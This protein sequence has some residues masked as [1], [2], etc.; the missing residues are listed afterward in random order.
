[1]KRL[2]ALLLALCL[3]GGAFTALA[4]ET[5]EATPLPGYT[6]RASADEV[7]VFAT[8]SMKANIVGYILP[9]GQQEVQVLRVQGEWCYIRFTS[10]YGDSYGYLPLACF[11]VAPQPTATPTPEIGFEVGTLAWVVNPAEGYRVNLREEPSPT[12]ASVGKYYT[13]TPLALTG[14]V[15][16]GFAQ[17]LLADTVLCWLDT[18]FLTTDALGFVPEMPVVSVDNPGSGATLRDLPDTASDRLGWYEHGTPVT[19]LG[20]RADGWYHVIV[21]DKIGYMS[22]AM[23]SGTFPYE[24]GTD[25]DD[26]RLTDNMADGETFLY[27]NTRTA[28]GQLH[29]RKEASSNS[30]SV[31]K[32][33]S[34]TAVVVVSYTRT[35][36]A[37]VRIGH[38]EGYMDADYLTPDKPVQAGVLRV[39]RNPRASGLNLRALPSTGSDIL[40]FLDNYSAVTVLGE[41][42][43]GWCYVQVCDTL[44]YMMGT[45]LEA[46]K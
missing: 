4:E 13:G 14:Q 6:L 38:T 9:G 26:P 16:N 10:A 18:R 29:L 46:D 41:L 43:D 2:L 28:N 20:V 8:A 11:D 5:P 42:S 40:A 31:G 12:A 19:V 21:E 17:V 27:V 3:M 30:R 35:G 34:G 32:F 45:Y 15:V 22:E 33:Y 39:I 1:M 25:S 24:Y 37:Y 44:G 23:L 7:R 36:W